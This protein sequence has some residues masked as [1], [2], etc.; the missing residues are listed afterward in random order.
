[1]IVQLAAGNLKTRFGEYRE[2]LFYDGQKESIAL[3]MGD[4]S[5]A[6]TL[7]EQGIQVLGTQAT[8]L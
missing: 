3:V 7:S 6:D 4:V 5:G 1:M 8:V 2:L